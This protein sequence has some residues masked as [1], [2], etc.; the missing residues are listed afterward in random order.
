MV[1]LDPSGRPTGLHQDRLFLTDSLPGGWVCASSSVIRLKPPSV[2]NSSNHPQRD[3]SFHVE[4]WSP[5]AHHVPLKQPVCYE[6]KTYRRIRR[7]PVLDTPNE[8]LWIVLVSLQPVWGR[9]LGGRVDVSIGPERT[10]QMLCL[11]QKTRFRR[12]PCSTKAD[13]SVELFGHPM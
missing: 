9:Y 2:P 1:R 8:L 13:L 6:E 12:K 7:S 10:P 3:G 11:R 4:P 5:G